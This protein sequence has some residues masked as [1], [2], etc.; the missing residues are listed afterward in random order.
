MK[1]TLRSV[2][3]WLRWV[4]LVLFVAYAA[5]VIYRIPAAGER[6]KSDAAVA[7][8]KAQHI[9]LADVMGANL[10]PPPDKTQNDATVAGIDANHNGIR[11]DVELAIFAKY[12]NSA[13]IRAA[14][15]QYAMAL[16][17][18]LTEVN[19]IN[20]A[21]ASDKQKD[22]SFFCLLNISKVNDTNSDQA[23]ST[24]NLLKK[25]IENMVENT[26]LRIQTYARNTG[27][28]MPNDSVAEPY[29]DLDQNSL[30]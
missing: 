10:P 4:L 23:L 27:Y 24:G 20:T 25:E 11:D 7:Q 12:P 2:W 18:A 14:E 6:Q 30:I 19:D 16:Q 28:V 29:C 13:K 9:T 26:S 3:R 5:L 15:L 17:V 1:A 22:L 8:I 21:I